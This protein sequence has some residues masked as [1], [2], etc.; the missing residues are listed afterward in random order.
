MP[1]DERVASEPEELERLFIERVNA[2]DIEGLVAL[3]EPDAVMVHAP[4]EVATGSAAIRR[5]FEG[6]V[7]SGEQ[8]TLGRQRPSLRVGDL[9]MGSTALADGGV[10]SEVAR[11]GPD[12]SW[13]WVIDNW[14]VLDA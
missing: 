5:V 3:F 9:A 1:N 2:G 11:R 4:G 7:A 12:G 6:L 10:T 14:N 13:R 8:L